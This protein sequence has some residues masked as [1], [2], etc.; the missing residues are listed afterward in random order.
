MELSVSEG[1]GESPTP[2]PGGKH[3]EDLDDNC[4]H[5]TR[6]YRSSSEWRIEVLEVEEGSHDQV[7]TMGMSDLRRTKI[8]LTGA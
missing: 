3:Y 4:M 7:G 1:L 2:P 8:R 5:E 6:P